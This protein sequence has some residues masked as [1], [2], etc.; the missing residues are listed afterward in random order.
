MHPLRLS[1]LDPKRHRCCLWLQASSFK[2]QASSFLQ[3][4]LST[5]GHSM[6]GLISTG[7]QGIIQTMQVKDIYAVIEKDFAAVDTLIR[8]QL[9][10]KVPLVEKIADY[11][12]AS[13]G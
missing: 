6:A 8:E 4:T 13:G 5:L 2:L 11:I 9:S 7:L 3:L 1:R 12:V 10:S